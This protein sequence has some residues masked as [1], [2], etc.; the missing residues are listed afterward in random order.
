MDYLVKLG[1]DINIFLII[2]AKGK[3]CNLPIR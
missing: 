1:N 2:V 3:D